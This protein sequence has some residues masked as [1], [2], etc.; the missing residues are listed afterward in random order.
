MYCHTKEKVRRVLCEVSFVIGLH[1]ELHTPSCMFISLILTD[2]LMEEQKI[3]KTSQD[4]LVTITS[5]SIMLL[6]V[7]VPAVSQLS[8]KLVHECIPLTVHC[9]NHYNHI[10]CIFIESWFTACIFLLSFSVSEIH[11][12]FWTRF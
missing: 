12:L 6:I 9:S 11:V 8:C 1:V 4:D 2:Q 3:A 5:E 7:T 10:H